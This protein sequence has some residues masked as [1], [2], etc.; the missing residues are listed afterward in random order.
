M[1][2]GQRRIEI[3]WSKGKNCQVRKDASTWKKGECFTDLQ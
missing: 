2:K 3:D 1:G